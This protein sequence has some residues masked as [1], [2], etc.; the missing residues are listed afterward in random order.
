M[1]LK[2]YFTCS[3]KYSLCVDRLELVA[4]TEESILS[5]NMGWREA[6]AHLIVKDSISIVLSF[7][8]SMPAHC[9]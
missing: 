9:F 1:R 8:L 5:A 7:V 2:E 3:R 6:W 4:S